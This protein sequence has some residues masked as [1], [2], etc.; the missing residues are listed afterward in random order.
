MSPFVP[1]HAL[2]TLRRL[3]TGAP[4]VLVAIAT[5]FA[6][7]HDAQASPASSRV[8]GHAPI[9]VMADHVHDKGEFMVSYRYMYM[10]MNQNYDGRRQVPPAEII[11]PA[12]YDYMVSPVEMDM[13]MHMFGAMYAPLDSLTLA[14]MLPVITK[15]MDHVR[16]MGDPFTTETAGVGDFKL[17]LLY[18]PWE[19]EHQSAHIQL[20]FS[21][22]TGS[23]DEAQPPPGQLPYPMQLGS[24]TFD[25][26]VGGTYVGHHQ[27]L[28]WGG[29]VTGV[30]R[31]G[32]NDRNYRL[33]HEYEVTAWS[34]LRIVDS[35]SAS[36]RVAW[37]QNFNIEGADPAL[38]PAMIPTADP[39]L[40]AGRRLDGLLGVNFMPSALGERAKSLKGLRLAV[41]GGLPM[42]QDLDG[43]QLGASWLITTGIQYAF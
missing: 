30:I 12:G 4:A 15:S 8:D 42:Y 38:N 31:L 9:G 14:A 1:T 33:G 29:Q 13:H 6:G 18:Q 25:L 32:E 7:A 34:A 2:Q 11:S 19:T 24:G 10:A 3:A 26:I 16:R 39:D 40:R 41:E 17:S 36:F 28:S 35:V 27:D 43:P 5:I 37:R 23:I 21:S 20:G 22:P